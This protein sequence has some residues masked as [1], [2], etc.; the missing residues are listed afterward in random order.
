MPEGQFPDLA[1]ILVDACEDLLSFRAF[2]VF[3]WK[4]RSGQR[5]PAIR[6]TARSSGAP[7]SSASSQRRQRVAP[8]HL[9]FVVETDDEWK[10]AE[11]RYLSEG[12][13]AKLCK[14]DQTDNQPALEAPLIVTA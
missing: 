2:P 7:M 3:H 1:A 11:R 13:M 6:S 14:T 12:S 5:T 4:L 10:V 8:G 9:P